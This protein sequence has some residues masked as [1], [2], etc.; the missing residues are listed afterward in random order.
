MNKQL[1][2]SILVTI[3][4]ETQ[5]LNSVALVFLRYKKNSNLPHDQRRGTGYGSGGL[6]DRTGGTRCR[7]L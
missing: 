2:T 3:S 5:E 1:I 7:S 6:G 4:K